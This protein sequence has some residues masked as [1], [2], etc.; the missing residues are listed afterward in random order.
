[1]K[2]KFYQENIDKEFEG[3]VGTENEEERVQF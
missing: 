1:M 2:R 3:I